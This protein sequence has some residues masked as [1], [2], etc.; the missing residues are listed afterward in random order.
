MEH[1][2]SSPCSQQPTTSPYPGPDEPSP[3]PSNPISLRS[4]LIL[5]C[6]Q[7]SGLPTGL[8]SRG[9]QIRILYAFIISHAC[10]RSRPSH[11]FDHFSGSRGQH[12]SHEAKRK[13]LRVTSFVLFVLRYE[14]RQKNTCC[15]SSLHCASSRKQG[16]GWGGGEEASV[17]RV[18]DVH[19]IMV[20]K[21]SFLEPHLHE[22]EPSQWYKIMFFCSWS[23]IKTPKNL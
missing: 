14:L 10:C 21:G 1:V 7:R 2:S 17:E 22:N 8:P 13:E 6:H 23:R 16:L 12:R 20:I 3:T 9:F 11:S 18:V 15:S 4:I 5:S 19:V